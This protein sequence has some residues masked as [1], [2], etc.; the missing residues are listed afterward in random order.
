M[1]TP[2]L[3]QRVVITH[4][5]CCKGLSLIE[6]MIAISILAVA[7]V[8]VLGHQY[9]LDNLR[10][11]SLTRALQTVAVNN[12]VNLVDGSNWDEL[13]R[14]ERPWSLSRLQAGGTTNPSLQL[15][16]LV[17][18]GVVSPETG[19]FTGGRQANE[20]NGNLRFYLEYY[21][22]TANLDSS[23]NPVATQ[24]GLLDTQQTSTGG[25][26]TAFASM[27]ATCRIVPDPNLGL[28]DATQIT[29]G[30]PVMVR[31][32]VTEVQPST[33]TQRQVYETFLGAQ[34]APQ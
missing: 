12:L 28:V 1:D 16:D 34:T 10:A 6:V 4:Q 14:I 29:A 22:A 7:L 30:N 3:N 23:L 20:A 5:F 31:L 19:H 9:T 33:G 15:A 2:Y 24:P 32:A 13:G 17:G 27:A 26:Q 21:R 25:F 8:A 18:A 11:H